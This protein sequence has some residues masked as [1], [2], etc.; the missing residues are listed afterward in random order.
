MKLGYMQTVGR[1]RLA[2]VVSVFFIGICGIA[3][4]FADENELPAIV[5]AG[6]SGDVV[7]KSQNS[8]EVVV[9]ETDVEDPREKELKELRLER[10]LI[11]AKN[12]L[13][14]AK[15]KR[16]LAGLRAEKDKLSLENSLVRE[17]M[18][19]ELAALN[20]ETDKLQAEIDSVNKA[21][22]LKAAVARKELQEEFAELSLKEKRLE[23][24]NSILQK[25]MEKELQGLRL[26]ETRLKLERTRLEGEVA[27]LQAQLAIREK[28]EIIGDQVVVDDAS[29]YLEEPFIDGV[30]RV[31]DRR[32]SLNGVI[33]GGISDYVIERINYFN[34]Q[35]TEHPIFIVIDS[36]PGGSVMAGYQILKAMEGSEAPVYVV[37]KAYAA[38][39]A[40]VITTLAEKS[41]AYPNAVILHHQLSWYG[42]VGNLTEQ[43]E[44][45][46]E[47]DEWWRR[48]AK[49]V[50]KKMGVPLNKFIEMM[51]E[52]K[53]SG[54]WSEF[55]DEAVRLG[56]V[57]NVVNRIWETSVDRNPDR[58]ASNDSRT[59]AVL[60]ELHDED[61]RPYVML[62]RL[63]AF[64]FYFLYDKSNYYRAP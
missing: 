6:E 33:W 50:A 42:V 28:S 17:R 39:M 18:S 23:K 9:T 62:P 20:A 22:T 1:S 55:G 48:L 37:V 54:D 14:A 59:Q 44:Y 51:Y 45:A 5:V 49:P 47:A 60:G 30:L 41:Y 29:L 34:N 36:S 61:G 31:S 53:S 52:E 64:D 40:A 3:S 12:A 15:A 56:W 8:S 7:E 19:S 63:E 21:V 38:S 43:K 11:E 32:I 58:F 24:E 4:T 16:D 27:S 46:D 35:S 2:T 13:A 26:E 25:E 10:D 57:D